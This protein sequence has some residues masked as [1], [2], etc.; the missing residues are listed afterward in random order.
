VYSVVSASWD[1]PG[2]AASADG[3][4]LGFAGQG[5]TV[6]YM[7]GFAVQGQV[8]FGYGTLGVGTS[9]RF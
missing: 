4:S 5:L 2:A 7:D 8:G 9:W 1:G 3:S 6:L